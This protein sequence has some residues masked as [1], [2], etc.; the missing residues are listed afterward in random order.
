M[1][2]HAADLHRL[3]SFKCTIVQDDALR[4]STSVSLRQWVEPPKLHRNCTIWK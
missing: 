1:L 4:T 2:Y 3:C